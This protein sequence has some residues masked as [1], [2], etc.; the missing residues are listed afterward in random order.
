ML[1]SG[2]TVPIE[3]IVES[4]IPPQKNTPAINSGTGTVGKVLRPNTKYAAPILTETTTSKSPL[5]S[6]VPVFVP[7]STRNTAP[8]TAITVNAA[9]V[10]RERFHKIKYAANNKENRLQNDNK[11]GI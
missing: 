5:I 11:A 4:V 10:F 9:S 6:L 7:T 3:I 1:V 8:V 2:L